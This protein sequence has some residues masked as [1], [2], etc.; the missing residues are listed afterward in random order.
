M[1]TQTAYANPSLRSTSRPVLERSRALTIALWIA[2]VAAAGLFLMAG[3]SKLA[4]APAM[5]QMFGVIGIGQW[6][7]YLT[8]SI[9]VAGAVLL[10]VPSL[11]RLGGAVLAATMV[12]A[13]LTHLF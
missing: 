11:A 4:G 9:E 5:V 7:R 3:T 6:F 12:G 8:G 2:Q 1:T 13:V 10:L